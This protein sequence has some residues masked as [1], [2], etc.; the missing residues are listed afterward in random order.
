MSDIYGNVASR[1]GAE[2]M[3]SPGKASDRLYSSTDFVGV[4]IELENVSSTQLR[5][6]CEQYWQAVSDHSLKYNGSEYR[7]NRAL[8]GAQITEALDQLA[9]GI[10][11]LKLEPYTDGNRGSDHIHINV[12]DLT[13]QQLYNFVLLSYFCEPMLMDVC[14]P[15]RSNS[16]FSISCSKTKDQIQVLSRIARGEIGFSDS[17]YKYRAI[18]L[19]SIY[20]KGSLEFRMFHATHN[21][22][23]ILFWINSIMEIKDIAT[24][25][26]NL[27]DLIKSAIDTSLE[28]VMDELGFTTKTP[29]RPAIELSGKANREIWDFVRDFSFTPI[30]EAELTSSKISDFYRQVTGE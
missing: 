25:R 11:Y 1:I 14:K 8:N 27:S 19:N 17:N 6:M 22:K 5:T 15:D 9:E 26:D 16:P 12:S 30:P 3:Y 7:F 21:P 2:A 18:G 23:H 29:F 4:E 20:A 24:S 13:L 10:D 28:H